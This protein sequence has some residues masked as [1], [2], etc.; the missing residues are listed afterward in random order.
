MAL[1]PVGLLTTGMLL[2]MQKGRFRSV[3]LWNEP[4]LTDAL[5]QP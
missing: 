2:L 3:I 5:S 1:P 4:R